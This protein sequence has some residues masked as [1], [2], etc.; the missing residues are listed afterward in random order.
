[1][2][3]HKSYRVF[4]TQY[5]VPIDVV[6]SSTEEAKRMATEDS[7]WEVAD[8]DIRVEKQEDIDR[9]DYQYRGGYHE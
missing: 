1:M 9:E 5:C 3:E 2:S 6:A 4:I 8:C 7:E